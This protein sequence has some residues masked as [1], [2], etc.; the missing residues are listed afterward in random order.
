MATSTIPDRW[1]FFT[2]GYKAFTLKD[3]A[4]AI[5][6]TCASVVLREEMTIFFVG[7]T[8]SAKGRKSADKQ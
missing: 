4:S 2:V 1:P 3:K 8:C 6:R 5:T 7:D